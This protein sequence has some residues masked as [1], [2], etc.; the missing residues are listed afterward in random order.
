MQCGLP[1]ESPYRF[2]DFLFAQAGGIAANLLSD[3][4]ELRSRTQGLSLTLRCHRNRR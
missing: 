1:Y 2:R 3:P 4:P